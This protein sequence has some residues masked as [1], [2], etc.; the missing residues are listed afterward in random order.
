MGPNV[1]FLH[2][3]NQDF[4]SLQTTGREEIK[5]LGLKK[6]PKILNHLINWDLDLWDCFGREDRS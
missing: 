5:T 4:F 2:L 6:F 1:T 3:Y